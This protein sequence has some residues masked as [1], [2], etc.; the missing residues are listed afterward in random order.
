MNDQIVVADYPELRFLCWNLDPTTT[1]DGPGALALYERNWRHVDQ[2][3]LTEREAA[4]I[5]RLVEC[6]GNGV[7][8]V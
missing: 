5:E 1:V 7:L 8:L 3:R 4:L 2:D 6:Y